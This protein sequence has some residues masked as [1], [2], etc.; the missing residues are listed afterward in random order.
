[1]LEN[2]KRSRWW[3]QFTID[4]GQTMQ[5]QIG[6]L[7]LA[8]QR[9]ANEWQI[10][11]QQE[12]DDEDNGADWQQQLMETDINELN[13]ANVE[14][15][16]FN[17]TEDTAW[18]LPALADRPVIIRPWTPLYIPAG[19]ETIIFTSLP[20]WIRIDVGHP[21]KTLRDLAIRRP[22]DTWFGPSTMKGELCYASRTHGRLNFEN[23]SLQVHRAITQ[24]H[25]RN[26]AA[27]PLQLERLSLPVPYLSL[28]ETAEGLL[29]TQT[30]SMVRTRETDLGMAAFQVE[31]RPPENARNPKLV[32]GPRNAPGQNMIIRAFGALFKSL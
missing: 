3:G 32:S 22:P 1:M 23:I 30:V 29:W 26:R 12:E 9:Q 21:P 18:I 24:I 20:L 15:H 8:L 27:G 14:R 17:Q 13:Y 19:E 31:K 10:A 4:I 5:W 6:P 11:F 7:K 28:F 16:T 2:D 25:I